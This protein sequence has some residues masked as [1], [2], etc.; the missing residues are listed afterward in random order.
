MKQVM[1]RII[2]LLEREELDIAILEEDIAVKTGLG[3]QNGQWMCNMEVATLTPELFALGVLSRWVELVEP[4]RRDAVIYLLNLINFS[5]VPVGSF[6]LD[7]EDGE[8]IF[9]TSLAFDDPEHVTDA[10][11]DHV[12][13]IN[14]TEIDRYLPMIQAVAGGEDP[15]M[16]FD[17]A[18]ADEDE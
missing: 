12:V 11:I 1:D 13:L 16:V 4:E 3:G 18:R 10:M 14:W 15:L 2:A 9:R 8:V 5:G 6:E 17:A 7:I